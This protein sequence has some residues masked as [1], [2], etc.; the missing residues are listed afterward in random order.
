M[1]KMGMMF[2]LAL[3]LALTG[4]GYNDFQRLDEQTKSAWSEVL[5]QY[6][7]RADLIPNLVKT[8]EG[9]AKQERDVLVQVTEARSRVS[10]IQATPEMVNDPQA[11]QQFQRHYPAGKYAP[12]AYYWLGELYL[13]VQPPDLESSRQAFT[14]LLSQYPDNSKAPD[15]LYKLGKVQCMK[16][17]REKAKEYLDQVISRCQMIN[18]LLMSTL[19]RDHAYRFI[20]LGALLERADQLDGIVERCVRSFAQRQK[21]A[22]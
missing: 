15:A 22:A 20:K 2:V 10:S 16:G 4:C 17:N 19:C 18:G 11:F 21:A 1:K 13:V 9:F 6:Q 5:N 3:T 7:R 8:V 14:M 12:N